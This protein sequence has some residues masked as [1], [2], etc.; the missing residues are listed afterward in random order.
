MGFNLSPVAYR[1]SIPKSWLGVFAAVIFGA[2]ACGGSVATRTPTQSPSAIQNATM[3]VSG[4]LR[5]YTVFSPLSLD[6]KKLVPLV[7]A[8]HGYTVDSTEMET[9]SHFDDQATRGGFIVVYP[10][11]LNNSWN[12]GSCC[13]RNSNDDVG[14]IR[15]LI[16]RLIKSGH[17][18]RTQV[19]ATGMSN[20]GA[21]AQR[22]ACDLADRVTAVASVSGS[23][24][25][26]SCNPSR[27]ISV[28]E[29]HGTADSLVPYKGGSTPGLGYFPPTM[30]IMQR[31]ANVDGCAATPAVGQSGIATTY[32]WSGCRDGTSVVL[33]AIA[34]EDHTW[35]A[36]EN[37]PGEPD[38]TQVTWNFL[39]HAP[40]LP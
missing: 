30:S 35:F 40:P 3:T 31:W 1:I 7:V 15:D 34:G 18:D 11:G 5:S 16:D 4:E 12:A 26:V 32:S 33:E 8:I 9:S 2:G 17:I 29:M 13:G 23:L 25:T 24:L 37:M 36:P 20:G 28:M 38:A 19:F 10:Q 14:F 6:P 27:A 21:M 39:S 22:L